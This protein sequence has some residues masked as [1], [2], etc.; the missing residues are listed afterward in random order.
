MSNEKYSVLY[1]KNLFDEMASTY[2]IVNLVSSF[3][4]SY[5]WRK[6]CISKVSTKSDACI[7]DFMTGMGELFFPI[8]RH[9]SYVKSV[10]GIDV[11]KQMCMS[12]RV[13]A[14]KDGKPEGFDIFI[15]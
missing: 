13:E 11:S 15:F 1:V 9:L 14:E 6:V 8:K 7:V 2:G 10:I 4:F 3:G 12:A 5:L